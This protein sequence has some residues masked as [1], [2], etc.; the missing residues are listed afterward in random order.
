MFVT[1]GSRSLQKYDTVLSDW[2]PIREAVPSQI[3]AL[4]G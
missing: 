2:E 4:T 1:I 3:S